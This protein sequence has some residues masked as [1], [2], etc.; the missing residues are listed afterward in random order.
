[1]KNINSVAIFHRPFSSYVGGWG[2]FFSRHRPLCALAVALFSP[3]KL[4]NSTA[5]SDRSSRKMKQAS[6]YGWISD[7]GW[8]RSPREVWKILSIWKL[9]TFQHS[10]NKGKN[11]NVATHGTST[12]SSS[13][14][15]IDLVG[16]CAA[17]LAGLTF[18]DPKQTAND[19]Q[20][21]LGFRRVSK[22]VSVFSFRT[23]VC[24]C[25]R[26]ALIL[27]RA[28]LP[29]MVTYLFAWLCPLNLIIINFG[30]KILIKF[31]LCIY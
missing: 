16:A 31:W 9:A 17:L 25:E 20:Q 29:D 6:T 30:K 5:I 19:A 26:A 27:C 15:S 10:L 3:S 12:R 4:Y 23:R 28:G 2:F 21:Q 13:G 7:S 22:F 24:W 14:W 11:E 18:A 8:F 1:M